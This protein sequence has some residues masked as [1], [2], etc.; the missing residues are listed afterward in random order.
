MES[1]LRRIQYADDAKGM[2]AHSHS[3]YELIYLVRGELAVRFGDRVFRAAAPAAILINCLEEHATQALSGACER[4][5]YTFSRRRLD[6]LLAEPRLSALFRNH[7]GNEGHVFSL[8]PEEQEALELFVREAGDSG[9]FSEEAALCCLKLF[10]IRLLR[11]HPAPVGAPSGKSLSLIDEIQRE[12]DARFSEPIRISELA[13]RHYISKYY[14]THLFREVTGLTPKEYLLLNRLSC[15]KEL[16][17]GT[18]M[19][20]GEIAARCGFGDANSLIRA[21]KKQSS[22]TPMQYRRKMQHPW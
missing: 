9:S 12:L 6:A 21:F 20:A 4:R 15:A 22:C 18:Q 1:F 16:L 10:L 5:C 3:T 2:E 11:G 14:L 13:Q 17:A 8:Q 19:T 7:P